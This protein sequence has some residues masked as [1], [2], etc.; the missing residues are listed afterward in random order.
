MS[1]FSTK[2]KEVLA[3]I[4]WSAYKL[5]IEAKM[6]TGL[7]YKILDGERNPSDGVI[8]KLAAIP[9]LGVSA[10]VMYAWQAIDEYGEEALIAAANQ[11]MEKNPEKMKR[12]LGIMDGLT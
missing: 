12:A 1:M 7:L 8:E 11:L 9:Q 6:D 4:E 10:E 3:S 5:A 2:L